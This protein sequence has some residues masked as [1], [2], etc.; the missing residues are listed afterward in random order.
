MISN[1]ILESNLFQLIPGIITKML[2]LV[3]ML[4]NLY[5]IGI[6]MFDLNTFPTWAQTNHT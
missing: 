5:T 6:P 3:I 1:L 2:S 4:A